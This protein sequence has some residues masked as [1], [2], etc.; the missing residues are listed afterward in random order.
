MG[1]LSTTLHELFADN[2]PARADKVLIVDPGRQATYGQ[3]AREVANV[4][5][6]LLQQGLRPGDRVVI[7]LRKSIAEVAA[8][9]AVARVGGVVVN[10]NHQWTPEQVRYV[11]EDCGATLM[12]CD[13]RAARAATVGGLPGRLCRLLV[14]G[15]AAADGWD[16]YESLPDAEPPPTLVLDTSLAM[17]IYTS[18]STGKPKGVMLSHRNIVSGARSVARYLRLCG[19]D[20]LLGV[21]PYSFDYGFNQLSTMLLLGGTVVHQQVPMASEVLKT[22]KQQAVTG[23]AA[24]PPLWNQIVRYLQETPI[25]LPALRLITNSGGKIPSA[26]L[27]AMPAVFPGVEIFL[28][29]GLTEAFRS[30]YLEPAKFLKKKGS[31]GRAIPGAEVYVIRAGKGVAQP[32]EEG[33]LV[34]RGPLVSLGYW[35]KPDLTAQRIRP[36]PEL[37]SLIGDEPVVYSGDLVRVDEDGDIWFVGRGDSMIKT[38]GFRLSPD[39]VED[40]VFRSGMISEVIAFGVDDDDLG[41]VVHVAITPTGEFSEGALLRYCR[42]AMPSYMVPRRFHIWQDAMPRT[43]SGKLA[44][45]EVIQACRKLLAPEQAASN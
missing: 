29:Y 26:I 11:A 45:P 40:M 12:I 24:V 2:V 36:C 16:V 30:T 14:V 35:G 44:R 15:A 42:A 17:I 21:L 19:D 33:E 9:L 10:V 37:V 3:M 41:Q 1:A 18:G 38:S 25:E 34:H 20:R 27:N 28:M 6:W 13:K 5:A 8:M 7:H 39:E 4:A 23:I 43:A 22:A 31:I 32:G